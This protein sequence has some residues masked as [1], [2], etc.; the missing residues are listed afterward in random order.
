MSKWQRMGRKHCGKRRNCSLREIS[1][2]PTVF[3]KDQ[4]LFGRGLNKPAQFF[5]TLTV[6]TV[7]GL[8][9]LTI[10]EH[11]LS[12]SPGFYKLKVK[13]PSDWLNHEALGLASEKLYYS[14][15]LLN[16]EKSGDQD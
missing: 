11:F 3:S 10:L 4:G 14:Q 13:Q 15:M 6:S 12:S 2:F 16:N 8:Y 1:P 7:Q 5:K 9:L